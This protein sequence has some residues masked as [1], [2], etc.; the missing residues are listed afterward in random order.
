M[1]T[2]KWNTACSTNCVFDQWGNQMKLTF[3]VKA[4]CSR[5]ICWNSS[6]PPQV[7]RTTL[8]LLRTVLW[9]WSIYNKMKEKSPINHVLGPNFL[10]TIVMTN[11]HDNKC[12]WLCLCHIMWST[13]TLI[14]MLVAFSSPCHLVCLLSY[15]YSI[16][17]FSLSLPYIM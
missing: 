12:V 17:F 15:F 2:F 13:P 5:H 7:I 16:S 11:Y 8:K 1:G 9:K 4:G 14:L 10:P 3:L 6:D